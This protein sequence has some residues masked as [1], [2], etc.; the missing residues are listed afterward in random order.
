MEFDAGMTGTG[1]APSP[2][3]AGGHGKVSTV[4]LN[5]HVRR[6]FGRSKQ[7]VGRLVDRELLRDAQRIGGVIVLPAR[8]F[9]AQR[10]RVG[11][12]SVNFVRREVDKSRIWAGLAGGFEEVESADSIRVEVVEWDRCRLVMGGLGCR[13]DNAVRAHHTEEVKNTDPIADI[14]F[15]M[16][17]AR[18]FLKEPDLIPARVSLQSEKHRALVIVHSMN[19]KTPLSKVKAGLRSD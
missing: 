3:T 16:N 9:L 18:N 11:S 12:V 5:H 4:F 19:P 2:Q 17:K 13:V 14:Q 15:V 10:N 8:R 6:E 7:R 1:Q